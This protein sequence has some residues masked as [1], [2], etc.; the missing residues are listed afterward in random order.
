MQSP[1]SLM[2]SNSSWGGDAIAIEFDAIKLSPNEVP[3]QAMRLNPG[4]RVQ[5]GLSLMQSS[6]V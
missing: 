5:S 3:G 1:L 6:S 4:L 2:E